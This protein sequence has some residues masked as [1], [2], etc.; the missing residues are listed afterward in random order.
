[1]VYI[2]F[3]FTVPGNIQGGMKFGISNLAALGCFPF[4]RALKRTRTRSSGC[5]DEV[6]V[7]TSYTIENSLRPLKSLSDSLMDL[8][9]QILI[10]RLYIVKE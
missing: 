1:M 4:L 3:R 7:L 2:W 5:M 8:S 10:S 9:I 6:T